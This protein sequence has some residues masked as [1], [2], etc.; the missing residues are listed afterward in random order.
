[1]WLCKLA[2]TAEV[3]FARA[4]VTRLMILGLQDGLTFGLLFR[5][6]KSS[7]GRYL[8]P[9]STF[10]RSDSLLLS[11]CCSD[12]RPHASLDNSSCKQ[13]AVAGRSW[14]AHNFA[15]KPSQSCRASRACGNPPRYVGQLGLSRKIVETM[16]FAMV[17]EKAA[18][19]PMPQC[20]KLGIW[21]LHHSHAHA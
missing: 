2:S 5:C 9:S 7:P 20:I 3:C 18:H 21:I 11:N 6:P 1:M 17:S 14:R 4:S 12:L 8:F 19:K 13:E 10:P 15:A 16:K